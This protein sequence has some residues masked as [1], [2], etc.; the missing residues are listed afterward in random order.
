MEKILKL[1][2]DLINDE[3]NPELLDQMRAIA[4]DLQ[5]T[6]MQYAAIAKAKGIRY[7]VALAKKD[8]I[9]AKMLSNNTKSDEDAVSK[10]NKSNNGDAGEGI[11]K[12]SHMDG[13]I[14][15][16][17]DSG[18]D[19]Q[20][21]Q[22]RQKSQRAKILTPVNVDNIDLVAAAS[23]GHEN[24]H[25]VDDGM[26]DAFSDDDGEGDDEEDPRY[27]AVN[28]HKLLEWITAADFSKEF[29]LH[30]ISEHKFKLDQDEENAMIGTDGI[31][32]ICKVMMYKIGLTY[33]RMDIKFNDLREEFKTDQ[34]LSCNALR[35][36]FSHINEVIQQVHDE[37]ENFQQEQKN[38]QKKCLMEVT[39]VVKANE[40]ML[41][42][43][44]QW[45]K[46]IQALAM[47]TSCVAEFI[48]MQTAIDKQTHRVHTR[49]AS[50]L[51]ERFR[52]TTAEQTQAMTTRLQSVDDADPSQS[53]E[54]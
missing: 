24:M 45:H 18:E 42:D 49:L 22:S 36:D 32:K 7:N 3:T 37:L 54:L 17:I 20:S 1:N 16:T 23:T 4:A 14:Q 48:S 39:G 35:K 27:A 19:L 21:K 29:Q 38:Q 53:D 2:E 40:Q 15:P 5:E 34:K 13:I 28:K 47:A 50:D 43:S 52:I 6:L 9:D 8:A 31:L 25:L 12:L 41:T 26:P 10:A 30:K 11:E 51:S 46:D 33:K 44:K